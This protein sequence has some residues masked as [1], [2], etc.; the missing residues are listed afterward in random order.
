[1]ATE[2]MSLQEKLQEKKEEKQEEKKA[3]VAPAYRMGRL[4]NFVK[5]NGTVVR[6]DAEG[7]YHPKDAEEVTTLEY[8]NAQRL[9]YVHKL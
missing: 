5:A 7:V 8:Y 1:M 6:P 4:R 3:N 9:N 2:K